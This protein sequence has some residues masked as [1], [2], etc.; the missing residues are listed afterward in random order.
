MLQ[1]LPPRSSC[2]LNCNPLL[3]PPGLSSHPLALSTCTAMMEKNPCKRCLF[4]CSSSI[5]YYPLPE[6]YNKDIPAN[7]LHKSGHRTFS[8]A[9]G[10]GSNP[11]P[12]LP[13][14][15]LCTIQRRC[16]GP[17]VQRLKNF[18]ASDPLNKPSCPTKVIKCP[19]RFCK[20]CFV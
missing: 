12:L 5:E 16:Q 9:P 4:I 8:E 2:C 6:H 14:G 7:N 20:P 11:S 10:V 17:V 19:Q 1:E 18:G 15:Q 13:G 3:H